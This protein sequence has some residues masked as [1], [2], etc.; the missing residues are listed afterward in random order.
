[1]LFLNK[2]YIM[3]VQEKQDAKGTVSTASRQEEQIL[4]LSGSE[5]GPIEPLP[6]SKESIPDLTSGEESSSKLEQYLKHSPN[7]T[8]SS[9]TKEAASSSLF[10]KEYLDVQRSRRKSK[11]VKAAEGSRH[12]S[13]EFTGNMRGGADPNIQELEEQL[14][15]A[16]QGDDTPFMLDKPTLGDGNCKDDGPSTLRGGGGKEDLAFAQ[17]IMVGVRR[18]GLPLKLDAI[19]KGDNNCFFNAIYAQTQRPGVSQELAAG[20]VAG[21]VAGIRN[22]YDL[23]LKV[24]RFAKRSRLAVVDEFKR[25]YYETYPEKMWHDMWSKMEQDG[26]WADA[27][28]VQATAW[29]LHHDIHIVM[30]SSTEKMPLTT[31]SGS[32]DQEGASCDKTPLLLGYLNNTHYQ[33]LL[34]E[35]EAVLSPEIQPMRFSHIIKMVSGTREKAQQSKGDGTKNEKNSMKQTQ[36]DE[37][38]NFEGYFQGLGQG[39]QVGLLLKKRL[40][41]YM[42]GTASSTAGF[43]LQRGLKIM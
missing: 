29:F 19:T 23:R 9:D 42:S 35:D 33:S 39:E 31:I 30:A 15:I 11:D 27:I 41:F 4:N 36:T 17:Q 8:D 14:T 10:S 25:L 26:E 5:H 43:F 34:P 12:P 7:M 13:T 21:G 2:I 20:G 32:W 38:E 6:P 1:M 28:T 22:P 3:I 18:A 40:Y 16:I 24:A 37:E